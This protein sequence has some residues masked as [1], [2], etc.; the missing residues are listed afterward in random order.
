[1]K[2]RYL[3][4]IIV[5]VTLLSF[6][7]VE[8]YKIR[9]DGYYQT[10]VNVIGYKQYLRFYSGGSVIKAGYNFSEDSVKKIFKKEKLK[11]LTDFKGKYL[12]TNDNIYISISNI[13][14]TIIYNGV[15]ESSFI[16]KLKAKSLINGIS[17]D[18]EFYFT[19]Y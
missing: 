2:N 6:T 17:D 15:L 8:T 14:G 19:K 13:D 1:M 9:I 18:Y 11:K 7:K 10:P 5:C 16:L 4:I 12:I 3:A